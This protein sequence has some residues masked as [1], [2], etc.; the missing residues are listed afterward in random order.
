MTQGGVARFRD[1][2]GPK[3][4]YHQKY[5]CLFINFITIFSNFLIN[6]NQQ[7]INLVTFFCV[8]GD[9]YGDNA[10]ILVVS[11]TFKTAFFPPK[12]TSLFLCPP[13]VWP[14]AHC[15]RPFFR[16]QLLREASQQISDQ[17]RLQE[18]GLWRL[19]TPSSQ[20]NPNCCRLRGESSFLLHSFAACTF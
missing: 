1:E 14:G 8:V 13:T 19:R 20:Q 3:W 11:Y 17:D 16:L 15:C 4:C 6:K 5:C 10:L 9:F 7:L 18:T 12:L 2:W